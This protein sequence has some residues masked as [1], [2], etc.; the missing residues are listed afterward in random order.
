MLLP[1]GGAG[2]QQADVQTACTNPRIEMSVRSPQSTRQELKV[3]RGRKGWLK[4]LGSCG[5]QD[6]AVYAFPLRLYMWAV[7]PC[8]AQV[9]VATLT[10]VPLAGSDG[11]PSWRLPALSAATGA[12]SRRWEVWQRHSSYLNIFVPILLWACSSRVPE[13]A[14]PHQTLGSIPKLMCGSALLLRKQKKSDSNYSAT[15]LN[16]LGRMKSWQRLAQAADFQAA[17]YFCLQR[18]K[19]KV[20]RSKGSRQSIELWREARVEAQSN[21]C[22][23]RNKA[24]PRGRCCTLSTSEMS[25]G[26]CREEAAYDQRIIEPAPGNWFTQPYLT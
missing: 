19:I 17:A 5:I 25:H 6:K 26:S 16:V 4:W 14:N 11:P 1:S 9:S 13:S 21:A 8:L 22:C 24:R 18:N 20:T 2:L 3:P 10:Q 15:N 7:V 23:R 12:G